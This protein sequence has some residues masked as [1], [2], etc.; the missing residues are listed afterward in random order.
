M[1]IA[2]LDNEHTDED[3]HFAE[4]V[5]EDYENEPEIGQLATTSPDEVRDIIKYVSA[6]K[7]PGRDKIT[8]RA[9]KHLP[10]KAIVYLIA[11]I[12]RILRTQY[13]PRLC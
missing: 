6:K 1:K 2:C 9:I 7:A 13:F 4:E 5:E 3:I 8:N 11:I 12:N 10:L